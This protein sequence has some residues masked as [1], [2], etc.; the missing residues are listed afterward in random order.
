M[1]SLPGGAIQFSCSNGGVSVRDDDLVECLKRVSR[2]TPVEFV[3]LNSCNTLSLCR[4]LQLE[5]DIPV[6]LGWSHP[7]VPAHHC[8]AMVSVKRDLCSL[9]HASKRLF[10]FP[11]L[12]ILCPAVVSLP[13]WTLTRGNVP[14]GL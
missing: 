11:S 13:A 9:L 1:I 5:C 14:H 2:S 3:F 6:V 4:R 12:L 7:A 10:F 8:L